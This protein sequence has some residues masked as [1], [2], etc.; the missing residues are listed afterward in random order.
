M[1]SGYVRI[2]SSKVLISREGYFT[3]FEGYPFRDCE[4]VNMI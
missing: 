2:R 4:R 1:T 3:I